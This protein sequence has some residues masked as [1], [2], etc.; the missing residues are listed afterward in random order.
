MSAGTKTRPIRFTFR[1]ETPEGVLNELRFR[2]SRYLLA[3][4]DEAVDYFKTELHKKIEKRMTPAKRL[5]ILRDA[6]GLS[7]ADLGTEMGG[8]K[9]SRI[10]DWENGQRAISKAAARKLSSIF[11]LP[12]DRFI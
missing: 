10:S 7:Q 2:Y 9:A 8:I 3:P 6:H 5:R 12:A 1:P 11:H 4:K